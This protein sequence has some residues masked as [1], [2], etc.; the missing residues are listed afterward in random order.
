[1]P[2]ELAEEFGLTSQ[3]SLVERDES[4]P[5]VA[6]LSALPSPVTSGQRASRRD[7]RGGRAARKRW[8][9]KQ[10]GMMVASGGGPWR[11]ATESPEPVPIPPPVVRTLIP[12]DEQPE[13]GPSNY[14]EELA[15]IQ[16]GGSTTFEEFI[17]RTRGEG[18]EVPN[19]IEDGQFA[20]ADD[21]D[22][23]ERAILDPWVE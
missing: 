18:R 10:T 11:V 19:D 22:E 1:V 15:F 20:L 13:A 14:Q 5:S 17:D 6:S 8:A 16:H 4:P 2:Y 3:V 21:G 23:E 12:I 9:K 7:G